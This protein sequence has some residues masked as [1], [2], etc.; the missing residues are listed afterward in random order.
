M[1]VAD[2]ECGKRGRISRVVG[3]A[4]AI[5]NEF[6]WLVS[7]TRR[8]NHHCGGTLINRRSVMTAAHCLCTGTGEIITPAQIQVVIGR[9]RLDGDNPTAKIINLQN[10]IIHPQYKCHKSSNDIAILE[11]EGLGVEWS[12]TVSPA[13]LPYDPNEI[14]YTTYGDRIA[15][16]AGWGWTNEDT[17]EGK[18]SYCYRCR[19]SHF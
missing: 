14:G 8:G 17:H 1:L 16:V 7:L 6:P 13:C 19:H 12:D 11:L 4:E 18:Y 15:T 2:T 5:P 10:I 3:G 9:H